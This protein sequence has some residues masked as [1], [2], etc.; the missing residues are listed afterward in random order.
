[1]QSN[2]T[3]YEASNATFLELITSQRVLQ[4]A[5]ATSLDHLADYY[6]ALAE[7]RAAV[8][9]DDQSNTRSLSSGSKSK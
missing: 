2:R 7:L 3:A 5:E 1:V 6:V 4:D 9:A 8:G